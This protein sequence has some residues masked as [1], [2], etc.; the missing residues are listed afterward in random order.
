MGGTRTH[1]LCNSRPV[2]Y[3]PDH[4]N[5]PV[6]R[7]KILLT[8]VLHLQALSHTV[9][10]MIL[11]PLQHMGRAIGEFHRELLKDLPYAAWIPAILFPYLSF[12]L[13]I[14]ILCYCPSR[15]R[16]RE[17]PRLHLVDRIQM[18]EGRLEDEK[19]I[20]QRLQRVQALEVGYITFHL[21]EVS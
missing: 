6:A 1:N 17:D 2:S 13:V 21:L 16:R 8:I 4:R 11:E 18:L 9:A 14:V 3:Q 20:N 15:G 5:C 12:V 7:G 19:A 10:I